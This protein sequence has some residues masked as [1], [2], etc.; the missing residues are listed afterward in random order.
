MREYTKALDAIQDAAEHDD[1]QKNTAEITQQMMKIQQGIQS[2]RST[3][4]DEQA[5]AR[6][7]KDPEVAEM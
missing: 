1:E 7:M 6:A 3:E 4:T 2:Q 5:F